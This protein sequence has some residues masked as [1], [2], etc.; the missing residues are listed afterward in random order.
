MHRVDILLATDRPAAPHPR[1]DGVLVDDVVTEWASRH[2]QPYSLHL[3]GPAGGRWSSGAGAPDL[4]LDGVEFCLLVSG[5]GRGDRL[6][7]VRVR[8]EMAWALPG[9]SFGGGE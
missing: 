7:A 2:G 5:R 9:A 6:L 8:S 3:T 4:E 1:P